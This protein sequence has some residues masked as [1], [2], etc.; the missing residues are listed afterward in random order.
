M[1]TPKNKYRYDFSDVVL[2]SS[3]DLTTRICGTGVIIGSHGG[4]A[5]ILTCHHVVDALVKPR[6]VADRSIAICANGKRAKRVA[7][8]A[9][10]GIDLAVIETRLAV[11]REVEFRPLPPKPG[12]KVFGLRYA[13]LAEDDYAR[14][15]F[16]ATIV[17]P[18]AFQRRGF[19]HVV[20]GWMIKPDDGFTIQQGNS[21]APLFDFNNNFLGILSHQREGYGLVIDGE[22]VT[23]F[24]GSHQLLPPKPVSLA[25]E[26]P[27]VVSWVGPPDDRNHGSFGGKRSRAG[28]RLRAT[29]AEMNEHHFYADFIVEATDGTE[30][31]PPVYFYLHESYP[32]PTIR[33]TKL[34]AENRHA[35]LEDVY[36]EGGYTLGA[37]VRAA[38]GD[39]IGL[40]LDLAED[41]R[42]PKRL[43]QR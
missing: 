27:P 32:Q 41:K 12:A 6:G 21:G 7:S 3:S 29:F 23:R 25:A 37:Q 15:Q 22:E 18:V 35:V 34:S 9:K 20:K 16:A 38:N 11:A 28:R 17:R 1:G 31:A 26:T 42:L 10:A 24:L 39:W 30:I 36:G 43:R 5:R 8:G 14:E 2:L 19:S 13:Y 40:E 33:I 4:Q